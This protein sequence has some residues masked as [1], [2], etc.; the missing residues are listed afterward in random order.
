[1]DAILQKNVTNAVSLMAHHIH[2]VE[3]SSIFAKLMNTRMI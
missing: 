1:M 2:H 3:T